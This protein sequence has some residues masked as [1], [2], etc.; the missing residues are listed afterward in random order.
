MQLP[1]SALYSVFLEN[2]SSKLQEVKKNNNKK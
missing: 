2:V 1:V